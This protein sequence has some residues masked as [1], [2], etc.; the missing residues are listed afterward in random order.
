MNFFPFFLKQCVCFA[1]ET[2]HSL[3]AQY[4]ISIQCACLCEKWSIV[5]KSKADKLFWKQILFSKQSL[6]Q[7]EFPR[8]SKSLH[9]NKMW[10]LK[11]ILDGVL[12]FFDRMFYHLIET[13]GKLDEILCVIFLRKIPTRQKLQLKILKEVTSAEFIAVVILAI[14]IF[15]VCF[16]WEVPLWLHSFGTIRL[17]AM[18]VHIT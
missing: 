14:I 16:R 8:I 13:F 12:H 10:T 4:F 2:T 17:N 11:A 1:C 18:V 15:C 6:H 3:F 9:R 7:Y 5:P